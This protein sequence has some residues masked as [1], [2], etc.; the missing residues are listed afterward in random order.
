M[1][2]KEHVAQKGNIQETP[3]VGDLSAVP[4]IF[5]DGAQGY[6]L[7]NGVAKFNLFELAQDLSDNVVKKVVVAKVA[8]SPQTVRSLAH[9]LLK[10]ADQAEAVE[11]KIGGGE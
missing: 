7:V 10:S 3:V 4:T 2:D 1:A 11:G 6:V 8:M 9:W 5:A